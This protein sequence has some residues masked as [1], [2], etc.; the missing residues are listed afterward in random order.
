MSERAPGPALHLNSITIRQAAG[1]TEKLRLAAESGYAGVELWLHEVAPQALG[2]ADREEAARRYGV[3]PASAGPD[4]GEIR[5]LAA[6]RG[7]QI[8]GLCPPS[9]AAV[10]WQDELDEEALSGL[11]A[12]FRAGALLGARYVLLPMLG[13]GGSSAAIAGRL[14]RLGERAV[15]HGIELGLEPVGHVGRFNRLPDVLEILERAGLGAGA[16][17]IVDAFHFFRAGQNV[18]DLSALT[19]ADITAVHLNDAIDLPREQLLGHRHRTLPRR[20]DLG[21]RGLCPGAA[22]GR[23]PRPLRDRD[24]EPGA[25]ARGPGRVLPACIPG[26]CRGAARSPGTRGQLMTDSSKPVRV[27]IAGAGS[28]ADYHI[29]GIRAVGNAEVTVLLGRDPERT[30]RRAAELGV[31]AHSVDYAAVLTD[32]NVD[33]L[34]IATPDVTHKAM[35]VDA[36]AAGTPVLLQKP[37]AMSSAE[38]AE[39][40]AAAG[41]SGSLLTVSF[42]HRYFPEIRWLH[43]RLAKQTYGPV[44]FVRI[45]NA[46]P[47]AGWN[48]WFYDPAIV[49]GG[50]VMQLGV[51]GIDLVQ[52]LFGPIRS[53][54]ATSSA[55]KPE[56]TLDNG[57]RVRSPLEDN[58]LASYEF[59]GGFSGAHEMSFTEVGGCDRFRLEVYC[60]NATIWLRTDRAPAMIHTGDAAGWQEIH[61]PEEQLGQAHHAHWLKMVR[62]EASADDTARAGLSTL[63][64]AEHIYR[65]AHERTTLAISP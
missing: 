52:H 56:R 26:Q 48:D 13:D 37:M 12:S 7:L 64:V 58:V 8:G 29:G 41:H 59:A 22:G 42:M 57:R 60:E 51:H 21:H 65:A 17:L 55:M 2:A 14:A 32:S 44:H 46:T 24:P 45:R 6:E 50:V 38:C 30:A 53:V 19:S 31:P 54:A 16:G 43:R 5:R 9:H 10:R 28:I 33:A 35:A 62:G 4:V 20:R 11:E 23:L 25:L 39:I 3:D 1:L 63:Q 15:R 36:L 49:A 61:F 34:V 18:A 40:I 27:A 47:G